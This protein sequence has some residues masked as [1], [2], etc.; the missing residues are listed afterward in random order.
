M[1][2][3][4]VKVPAKLNL[5][6][7]VVGVNGNYHEIESLVAS[8][9]I[10]DTVSVKKRQ[11][12]KITLT[13]KGRPVDCPII[14]NNAYKTA[15]LFI[16]TFGTTG[17]DIT[18]EKAIPVAGGLGGSS[19]DIAGVLL[20]LNGLYELNAEIEAL[21]NDLGSDANYMLH[22]GYAVLKGRGEI[23]EKSDADRKIY[24]VLITDDK[25]VS[26]RNCYKKF[27]QKKK[28]YP[29]ITIDA[30]KSLFT[31]DLEELLPILKNDLGASASELAPN[32][33][34][35]LFNLKK[36][37]AVNA[38]VTGSGPTVCGFFYDKKS[39]DLC[40]KKLAPIYGKDVLKA[41]TVVPNKGKFM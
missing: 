17:V 19:A 3:F 29:S 24:V 28:L 25:P 36:A 31:G 33:K 41:E 23:V 6:L 21:A 40:Y 27:D 38:I 9:N 15:K 30:E 14:E 13:M 11:D 16:D 2:S 12:G 34:H 8:V 20:A 5:T 22:G 1:K 10:Y 26:A 7:D 35:N 39:R 4:K 32:V 18:V 37:G